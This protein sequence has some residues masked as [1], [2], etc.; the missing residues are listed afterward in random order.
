MGN[1]HIFF[2]RQPKCK[3]V[4]MFIIN[5]SPDHLTTA[6]LAA[7]EQ[8]FKRHLIMLYYQTT[9]NNIT[10]CKGRFPNFTTK[11]NILNPSLGLN[12]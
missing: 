4:E 3:E 2:K 8:Y 5:P 11:L 1:S 9:T 12:Y 6:P 7:Q 10:L